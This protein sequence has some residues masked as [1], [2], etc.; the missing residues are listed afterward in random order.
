MVAQHEITQ[1]VFRLEGIL[2]KDMILKTLNV[3]DAE[4]P[5]VGSSFTSV[6]PSMSASQRAPQA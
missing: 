4:E 2:P 3:P 5:A 1:K 6:S